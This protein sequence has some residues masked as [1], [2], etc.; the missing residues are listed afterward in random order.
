MVKT[1]KVNGLYLAPKS[2]EIVVAPFSKSC[3]MSHPKQKHGVRQMARF[4]NINLKRI[5]TENERRILNYVA[6]YS[7]NIQSFYEPHF[8]SARS[9]IFDI[10]ADG[11]DAKFLANLVRNMAAGYAF[12]HCVIIDLVIH[13]TTTK[14]E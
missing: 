11:R 12:N 1:L 3:T 13:L 9:I 14:A 5:P 2:N 7:L 4:E 6:D 8:D 10:V